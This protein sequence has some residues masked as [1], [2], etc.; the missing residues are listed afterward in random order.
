MARIRAAEG[1]A[2]TA[3]A[4]GIA[5]AVPLLVMVAD[6]AGPG[7][8]PGHQRFD[9]V[10]AFFGVA[11]ERRPLF[12]AGAIRLIEDG[13]GNGQ[14]PDVVQEGAPPELVR[15]SSERPASLASRSASVRTRSESPRVRRSW[16]RGRPRARGPPRRLRRRCRRARP[17]E[18]VE[19]LPRDRRLAARRAVTIR[20]GVRSGK[21]MVRENSQ[22]SGRNRRANRCTTSTTATATTPG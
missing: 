2:L 22:A 14:L 20:D 11:L 6:G 5:G 16:A 13:A 3:Q 19:R 18:L 7:P 8:E 4:P 10:C 15:S 21:A 12:V 1:D 9:E 17:A